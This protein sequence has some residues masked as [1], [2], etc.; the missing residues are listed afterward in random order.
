M[1][2]GCLL[3]KL[4]FVFFLLFLLYTT[5]GVSD[6]GS[7]SFEVIY[8]SDSI[9]VK[10][11]AGFSD[12]LRTQIL[13]CASSPEAV[14]ALDMQC[15]RTQDAFVE[16]LKKENQEVQAQFWNFVRYP[17]LLKIMDRYSGGK[18]VNELKVYPDNIR[19]AAFDFVQDYPLLIGKAKKLEDQFALSRSSIFKTFRV[20]DSISFQQV[21]VDPNAWTLLVDHLNTAVQ[22][23]QLS[24]Q[25]PVETAL[26]L[27]RVRSAELAAKARD[28]ADWKAQLESDSLVSN[29]FKAT[30]EEFAADEGD[31]FVR[32]PE[33]VVWN[34]VVNPYPYW[35]GYPWWYDYPLWYP[36]PYWYQMGY[37]WSPSGWVIYSIPS[38]YYFYWYFYTYPHPYSFPHFTDY[39][40]Q[41]YNRPRT[42]G[43]ESHHRVNT[44]KAEAEKHTVGLD[45]SSERGRA[46]RIR[47][48]APSQQQA[49]RDYTLPQRNARTE[50]EYKSRPG[51]P[52][53]PSNSP[54]RNPAQRSP[55]TPSPQKSPPQ[56]PRQFEQRKPSYR[57]IQQPQKKTPT[58]ERSPNQGSS[59]KKSV[60]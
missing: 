30:A 57:P 43:S 5:W 29:E 1:R 8:R 37:A 9:G 34:V 18:L 51:F 3:L 54:G 58:P 23:R 42:G 35:F 44:W 11:L 38:D 32:E 4:G 22:L 27:E 19:G 39:C 56:V 21:L 53:R 10:A 52:D 15:K 33:Q 50:T 12:S 28:L 40:I 59:W 20:Q 46:D 60:R 6:N 13:N 31:Q 45:L 48:A 17:G 16:L 49:F 14:S 36:Y 24:I 7:D 25:H 47:A 41:Y 55:S 2:S 26:A